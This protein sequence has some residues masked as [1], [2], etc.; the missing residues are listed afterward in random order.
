MVQ[1]H[2]GALQ[3][4]TLV[5]ETLLVALQKANKGKMEHEG[6]KTVLPKNADVSLM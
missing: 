2:P 3:D 6:G 1:A 5:P 4:A